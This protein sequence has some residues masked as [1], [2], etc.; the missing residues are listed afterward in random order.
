MRHLVEAALLSC[1]GYN[2]E[3]LKL[4]PHT[5]AAVPVRRLRVFY[6][7]IRSE[8][9]RVIQDANGC[10]EHEGGEF[11]EDEGSEEDSDWDS[12]ESEDVDAGAH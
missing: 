4:S 8:D 2:W 1:A 12:D 11:H 9:C 5:H 7:G 10:D 6:V 3:A